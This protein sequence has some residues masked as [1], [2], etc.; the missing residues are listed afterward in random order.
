MKQVKKISYFTELP[1]LLFLSALKKK[2]SMTS[3]CLEISWLLLLPLNWPFLL[4]LTLLNFDSVLSHLLLSVGL[5]TGRQFW[6]FNFESSILRVQ[7]ASA[8]NP[9]YCKLCAFTRC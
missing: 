6:Q 1:L 9:S 2:N 3:C 5:C 4:S 8:F 7:R